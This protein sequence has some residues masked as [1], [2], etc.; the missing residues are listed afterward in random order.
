MGSSQLPLLQPAARF[1]TVVAILVVAIDAIDNDDVIV[2]RIGCG[3]NYV[4]WWFP[5]RR[6]NNLCRWCGVAVG[7]VGGF[8]LRLVDV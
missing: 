3:S 5:F 8:D 7:V 2:V 6:W 4:S 1:A